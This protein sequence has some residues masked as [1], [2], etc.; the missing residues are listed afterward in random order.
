MVKLTFMSKIAIVV[1]IKITIAMNHDAQELHGLGHF[2]S[3]LIKNVTMCSIC[4][5]NK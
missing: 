5:R 4:F 1:Y 2:I 3:E